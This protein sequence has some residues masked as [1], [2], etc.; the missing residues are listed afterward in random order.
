MLNAN[1][2]HQPNIRRWD[3][4][5]VLVLAIG[6]TFWGALTV[7]NSPAQAYQDEGE[8]VGKSDNGNDSAAD[9][10]A[11]NA[12]AAEDKATE[13]EAHHNSKIT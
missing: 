13:E 1:Q 12:G 3:R 7:G 5:V 2:R 11:P 9:T 4:L 6:L 10:A 8:P